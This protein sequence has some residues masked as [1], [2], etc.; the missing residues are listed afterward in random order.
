MHGYL[1]SKECFFNQ[2][3]FFE[4]DFEVFAFDFKGF[5][6]NANMEKPYS[7]DDYLL[8]VKE[9]FYSKNIT[10][11][12][13]IAHSFGGR[14]ALKL[15]YQDGNFFDKIVLT[16]SAGLKPKFSVKRWGK[17]LAFSFL[18]KIVK[19]EK[20]QGFYSKD[21]LMLNEVMKQ[22]FIK[23]VNEHLDYTLEK[24]QNPTLIINGELDKETPLYTAKRLNKGIKNSRLVIIKGASHFAFID[25]PNTFNFETRNFLL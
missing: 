2:I 17:R 3:K 12:S 22:S 16:G 13:V 21:Y 20:L 4:K 25:K 6:D 23:I 1:A 19:K 24:I 14:V 9:Y 15:A 18:R 10:S 7:L 5:G 11:P 8:D